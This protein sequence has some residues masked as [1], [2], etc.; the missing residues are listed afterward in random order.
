LTGY[1]IHAAVTLKNYSF[2]YVTAIFTADSDFDFRPFFTM[3]EQSAAGLIQ[4]RFKSARQ[5][6]RRHRA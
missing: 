6:G 1:E 4:K 5:I 2:Q 3:A